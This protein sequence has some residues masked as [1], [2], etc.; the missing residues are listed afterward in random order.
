MSDHSVLLQQE[1]QIVSIA[2]AHGKAFAGR[3][4][5]E[6]CDG[7]MNGLIRIE[8]REE[9]ASFALALSDRVA[10]GLRA[11]TD[12]RS[13]I[14]PPIEEYV[15]ATT[16]LSMRER[17]VCWLIDDDA[18]MPYWAVGIAFLVGWWIGVSSA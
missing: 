1:G 18:R 9:A 15:E 2:G 7:T 4:A 13:L 6:I 12:F 10:G 17:L 16:T 11:P 8:G 14:A 3:L 5:R